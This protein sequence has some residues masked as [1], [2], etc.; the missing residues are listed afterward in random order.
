MRVAAVLAVLAVLADGARLRG[1]AVIAALFLASQPVG[2]EDH[3][4]YGGAT[5]S[6]PYPRDC[7]CADGRVLRQTCTTT[8]YG[9]GCKCVVE[10]CNSCPC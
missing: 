9:G 2:T 3:R 6:P 7:A 5:V 1:A 8:T 10:E 4:H